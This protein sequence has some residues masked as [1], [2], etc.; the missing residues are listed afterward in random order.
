ITLTLK[1]GDEIVKTLNVS[2]ED[3]TTTLTDLQYYKD[4]KLET[5]MVYDRGE[6]D[7]EEVLK[8]EPLRIDLKKVEIKDIIR[9][10][11]IKYENQV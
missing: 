6:G 5:K 7:E 11:L 3:L 2:P 8:E 1:K 10:D 4:Y 9:T